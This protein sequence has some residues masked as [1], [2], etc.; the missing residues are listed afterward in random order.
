MHQV[1]CYHFFIVEMIVEGVNLIQITHHYVEQLP[2]YKR[3]HIKTRSKKK[4]VLV[5]FILSQERKNSNLV[6][7]NCTQENVKCHI[8]NAES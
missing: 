5:I 2:F 1:R 8:E 7:K 3:V 4:D 6:D